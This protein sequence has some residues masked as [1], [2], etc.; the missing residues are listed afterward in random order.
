MKKRWTNIKGTFLENDKKV[1]ESKRSGSGTDQIFRPK[2]S[3]YSRLKFLK[4]TIYTPQTLSN[5]VP[6]MQHVSLKSQL[7][8]KQDENFNI[9]NLHIPS[10][11]T[12][13]DKNEDVQFY[14]DKPSQVFIIYILY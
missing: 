8:D 6:T 14:Y 11:E 4:K 13:C 5:F 9:T 2:W 7:R 1:R 3:L 12:S 10:A